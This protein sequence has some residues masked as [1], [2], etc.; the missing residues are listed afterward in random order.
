M[1]KI[2]LMLCMLCLLGLSTGCQPAEQDPNESEAEAPMEDIYVWDEAGVKVLLPEGTMEVCNVE[3]W[4]DTVISFALKESGD[5]VFCLQAI[6]KEEAVEGNLGVYT[7]GETEDF[8]IQASVSTCGTL[9]DE[10]VR[11]L[12]NEMREKV[13]QM[14][15][16]NLIP[17]ED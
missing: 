5:S 3:V 4:E 14:G 6:P 13:S 11:P 16:E 8:V 17:I 9:A 12:W 1:K 10:S 7:L 15:E 2:F